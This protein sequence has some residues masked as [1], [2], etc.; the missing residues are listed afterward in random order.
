VSRDLLLRAYRSEPVERTP[1]WFMRQAGRSLPEY[2]ALRRQASL[3]E[4]TRDP[5]RCAE[6][7]L[8]P[9][10]R[11]G[12]DGAIL[13]ADITS[14]LPGLGVGLSIVDGVGPV[15]DPPVRTPADIDRLPLVADLDVVAPLLEAIRLLRRESPVPL[16]GFAGA[17]F[18]LAAYLVEGRSARDAVKA[19]QLMAAEPEAFDR[20]MARLVDLTIAYLGAQVAAGVEAVQVFDS[21]VGALAPRDYER[22]VAPHDRRLFAAL[23][24]L[25]VPT[26]HFGTGNAGFLAAFASV[27]GTCL[28]LDWRVDLASGW[29]AAPGLAVQGNLDPALLLAGWDAVEPAAR[30]V[31]DQAGERPGHVFNLGHGVLPETDPDLLRRL[32][33][34]VHEASG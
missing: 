30:A 28:G 27:G 6:V 19:K 20:L 34:F 8:Q 3:L 13:F 26:I 12:V 22:S 21:W 5:A 4:M 16:L 7:T 14:P 25:G 9:V 17:P 11:L 24:G 33:D 1:V 32:V 15:I 29:A 23:A 2:R 18:T 10:T 31:L